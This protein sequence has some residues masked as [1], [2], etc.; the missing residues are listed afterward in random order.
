MR[1]LVG[2]KLLREKIIENAQKLVKEKYD[3]S[4][5]ARDMRSKVFDI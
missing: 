4:L 5:I 3:W 1:K 2:D